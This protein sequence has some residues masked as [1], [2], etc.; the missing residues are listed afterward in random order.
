MILGK[1]WIKWDMLQGYKMAI[2]VN[3][4]EI[5]MNKAKLAEAQSRKEK[6]ENDLK[7]LEGTPLKEA[8]E[9]LPESEKNDS[10]AIYDMEKKIKGERAEQ[11]QVFKNQIKSAHTEVEMADGE[12]ARVYSITY[13]NRRKYDFVRNYKIKATYADR[14]K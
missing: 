11:V 3:E 6:L 4:V 8:I 1:R 10:K 5:D 13:G 14:N 7:E 12:L 2:F 9:L